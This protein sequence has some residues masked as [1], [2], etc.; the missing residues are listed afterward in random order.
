MDPLAPIRGILWGFAFSLVFWGA[1]AALA[2]L[3]F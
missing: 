1:I 2:A 3:V